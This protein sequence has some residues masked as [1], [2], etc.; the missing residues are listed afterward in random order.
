MGTQK[1]KAKDPPP[2]DQLAKQPNK[3]GLNMKQTHPP[4]DVED[5]AEPPAKAT[6]ETRQDGMPT[7]YITLPHITGFFVSKSP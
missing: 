7:N 3:K 2:L 5:A 6:V 4:T 1:R